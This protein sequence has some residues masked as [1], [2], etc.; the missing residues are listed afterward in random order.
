MCVFVK[1]GFVCQLVRSSTQDLKEVGCADVVLLV[2]VVYVCLWV[3]C[4]LVD[5]YAYTCV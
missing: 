4:V 5:L 3:L 1:I 2:Y